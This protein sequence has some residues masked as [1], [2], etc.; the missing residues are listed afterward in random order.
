MPNP[1]NLCRVSGFNN[2]CL[3]NSIALG[4]LEQRKS[5]GFPYFLEN[6]TFRRAFTDHYKLNG[7]DAS[8]VASAEVINTHLQQRNASFDKQDLL[9]P[10][11]R[12]MLDGEAARKDQEALMLAFDSFLIKA[13]GYFIELIIMMKITLQMQLT[14]P[15]FRST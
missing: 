12:S 2:N 15:G 3:L 9:G 10:V 1:N 8:Y 4:L 7:N 14:L 6:E 13:H 11:L 5:N